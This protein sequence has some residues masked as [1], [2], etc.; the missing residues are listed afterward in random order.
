MFRSDNQRG[1]EDEQLKVMLFFSGGWEGAT[2]QEKKKSCR[3][4]SCKRFSGTPQKKETR[5]KR[6]ARHVHVLVRITV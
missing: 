5:K 1:R 4:K 3:K 6:A 2:L